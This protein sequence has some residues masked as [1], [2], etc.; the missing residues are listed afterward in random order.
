[1]MEISP[2]SMLPGDDGLVVQSRK[3]WQRCSACTWKEWPTSL[4]VKVSIG[5]KKRKE[6][7]KINFQIKIKASTK[8]C[9]KCTSNSCFVFFGL[10]FYLKMYAEKDTKQDT[11]TYI[12]IYNSSVLGKAAIVDLLGMCHEVIVGT[13]INI[14]RQTEKNFIQLQLHIKIYSHN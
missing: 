7:K 2:K 9:L 1:M 6:K 11:G 10:C 4:S 14:L 8:T 13:T 12:Y 3:L 5:F